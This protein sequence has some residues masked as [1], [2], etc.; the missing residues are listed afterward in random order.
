MT[1][2]LATTQ[3]AATGDRGSTQFEIVPPERPG[4]REMA[5]SRRRRNPLERRGR[6]ERVH[7]VRCIV[8]GRYFPYKSR[9]AFCLGPAS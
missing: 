9:A 8:R 2:R 4:L 7:K 6:W 1:W 3:T 5:R